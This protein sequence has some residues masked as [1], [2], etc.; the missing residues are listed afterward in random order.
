MR[1]P[2]EPGSSVYG[3]KNAAVLDPIDPSAK[4]FRPPTAQPERR[5]GTLAGDLPARMVVSVVV[6]QSTKSAPSA[7][8]PRR[9]SAISLELQRTG[10]HVL[11]RRH[12]EGRR[13]RERRARAPK[14]RIER[15]RRHRPRHELHRG[16][17]RAARSACHR[18]RAS[19]RRPAARRHQSSMPASRNASEFARAM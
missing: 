5:R 11:D 17:L 6:L 2:L 16:V 12:A 3:S 18:R 14:N 9:S 1:R 4:N 15:R 7:R 19:P 8:P 10:R 13:V